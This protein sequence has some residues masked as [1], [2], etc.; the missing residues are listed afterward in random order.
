MLAKSAKERQATGKKRQEALRSAKKR[1]ERW[2]A[3]KECLEASKSLEILKNV[4][5]KT[6]AKSAKERQATGLKA[7]G[8][9]KKRQRA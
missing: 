7:P 6:F 9:A 5:P 8:S 3:P 2:D 4:Y 1:Q